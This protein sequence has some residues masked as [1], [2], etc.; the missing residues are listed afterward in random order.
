MK[1]RRAEVLKAMTI[2]MT[3]ERREVLIREE[4]RIY[5]REEGREEILV[6]LVRQNLLDPKVAM[7]QLGVT[8][9]EWDAICKNRLP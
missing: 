8:Q 7:M 4:E 5:G 9:E 1:Q 2:D 6:S 3:F